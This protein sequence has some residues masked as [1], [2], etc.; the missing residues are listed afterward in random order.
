MTLAFGESRAY[1]HGRALLTHNRRDF[2]ILHRTTLDQ[3]QAHAGIIV[4]NRR[5]SDT[6]L[7][8]RVMRF[9][10]LFTADEAKNQLFYL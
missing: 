1:A 6:D 2:E 7:A 9:L 4:A 10:D 5:P 8:R 3:Q